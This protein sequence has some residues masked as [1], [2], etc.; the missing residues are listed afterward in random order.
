MR[1]K[2]IDY[3][4]DLLA[5]PDRWMYEV[6]LRRPIKV[7]FVGRMPHHQDG[8]FYL[9]SVQHL[10]RLVSVI[11][12]ERALDFLPAEKDQFVIGR[13]TMNEVLSAPYFVHAPGILK[14]AAVMLSESKFNEL[15]AWSGQ[16]SKTPMSPIAN[17]I[18]RK[19]IERSR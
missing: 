5:D 8:I 19:R 4:N 7:R 2:T 14:F 15:L 6:S 13:H 17:E 11:D 9:L 16:R 10:D 1:E 18:L 12:P 3:Y